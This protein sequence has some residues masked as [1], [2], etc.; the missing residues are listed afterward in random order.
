MAD[1]LG[2]AAD[3]SLSLAQFGRL[4]ACLVVSGA[5]H[6][7]ALIPDWSRVGPFRLIGPT[8]DSSTYW[9]DRPRIDAVIVEAM[10]PSAVIG[11][12]QPSPAADPILPSAGPA[13]EQAPGE[14]D[15]APQGQLPIE[16]ER[17]PPAIDASELGRSL[18][19]PD[20]LPAEALTRQPELVG[21]IDETLYEPLEPG[22]RGRIVIR[23]YLNQLGKAER[24]KVLESTLPI[25]IEGSVVR[26]FYAAR[27]RPGEIDGQ[28]VMSEMTI[29][30]DLSTTTETYEPKS[31]GPIRDG[32]L[33]TR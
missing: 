1:F 22:F 16:V 7:L 33:H 21:G 10:R 30:V 27:Y 20:Y 2:Y 31:S 18:P 6:V 11:P 3:R 5:L 9:Q 28:A 13:S 4:A 25:Q 29:D 15:V 12:V 17:H 26:A 24:V 32:R 23:L 8:D 14:P 19:L